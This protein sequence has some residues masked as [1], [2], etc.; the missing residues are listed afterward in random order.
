MNSDTLLSAKDLSVRFGG[1]LAVNK[2]SFDVKQGEVFTLIGPN[3]AGKTTVF[4]L[5]SRIYTPTTGSITYMGP[6]GPLQ[7]T[8]QAPQNVASLGI[9]RTFQ[10][11]ELFEHASVLHNL[12]IG[13]HTHRK[14]SLW[15]DLLFTPAVREAELKA[16][17]KAEEVIEFLDL[18]HY[19]DSLVAGLP[20]GVRKV[21]EMARALC[22]E[23]KLLLLDEP[24]SGLNV[25]ETDDMAFWI[26]D[27]KNELGITVL[28]VEHDM[29][30]VS[31]VSDRVLAMNQGE[32]LAMGSPREV[33]T[34]PAVVEAY[35]GSID[36]VSSLR[37]QP[38][39]E[40]A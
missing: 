2:V 37:R 20:Y 14:T 19:R 30:L 28:M 38:S 34:D 24:S 16:R 9:A 25:E 29:S 21:V 36:D 13:R 27:I 31:K 18:Q 4:N 10:N 32:V 33:Q 1:V 7:L 11:I 39:R 8:E 40:A 35:L 15:Q 3:G 22:T 17:E 23:P 5:I 12:L 6:Q 26:Q